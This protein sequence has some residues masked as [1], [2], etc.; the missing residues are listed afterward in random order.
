MQIEV[1]S[2]GTPKKTVKQVVSSSTFL[3]GIAVCWM[4]NTVA[5]ECWIYRG[6]PSSARSLVMSMT[7][8]V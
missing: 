5:Q 8:E 3:K 1:K 4:I 2:A 6:L 7:E